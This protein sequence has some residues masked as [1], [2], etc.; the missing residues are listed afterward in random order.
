MRTLLDAGV[1]GIITDRPDVLRD[2]L[3]SRD[4]W[5]RPSPLPQGR[6]VTRPAPAPPR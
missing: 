2:V 6:E 4:Q 3:I 1:D 5:T